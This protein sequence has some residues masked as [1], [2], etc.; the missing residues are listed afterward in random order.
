MHSLCY[1][2][3]SSFSVLYRNTHTKPSLWTPDRRW[4]W[5]IRTVCALSCQE[6]ATIYSRRPCQQKPCLLCCC[7]LGGAGVSAGLSL[8]TSRPG[9]CGDGAAALSSHP[10]WLCPLRW[11]PFTHPHRHRAEREAGTAAG[12][13]RLWGPAFHP[14]DKPKKLSFVLQMRKLGLRPE[15]V[16]RTPCLWQNLD[17]LSDL[18]DPK[19]LLDLSIRNSGR[20]KG[21]FQKR[22]WE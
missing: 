14:Q 6:E 9:A 4:V 20:R 1:T 21:R 13:P 16:T 3:T 18:P 8:P 12:R 5:E 15:D 17:L 10:A 2:H 19:P 22:S 11:G 7:W